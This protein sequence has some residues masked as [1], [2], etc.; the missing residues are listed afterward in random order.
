MEEGGDGVRVGE[1]GAI[2]FIN[3]QSPQSSVK[4]PVKVP[5]VSTKLQSN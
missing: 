1:T 5:E 4:H 2:L 3:S